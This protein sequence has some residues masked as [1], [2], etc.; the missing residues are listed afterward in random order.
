MRNI[1]LILLCALVNLVYSSCINSNTSDSGIKEITHQS[2]VRNYYLDHEKRVFVCIEEKDSLISIYEFYRNDSLI[3]KY[4]N[5]EKNGEVSL[6]CETFTGTSIKKVSGND[7]LQQNT[8]GE[9]HSADS[10]NAYYTTHFDAVDSVEFWKEVTDMLDSSTFHLP[11]D[12]CLLDS[13]YSNSKYED[14]AIVLNAANLVKKIDVNNFEQL[15][16]LFFDVSIDQ[17]GH[18]KSVEY[19]SWGSKVYGKLIDEI[20]EILVSESIRGYQILQHPVKVKLP[21]GVVIKSG[22]LP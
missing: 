2:H 16:K 22:K 5:V 4:T 14:Q 3:R 12:Q 21:I 15:P 20:G 13:S 18:I 19:T 7:S 8:S 10:L 1:I 11:N 17:Q 6:A 9:S